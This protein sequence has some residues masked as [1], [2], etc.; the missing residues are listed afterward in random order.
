[1]G[2]EAQQ[3]RVPGPWEQLLY[4]TV[5]F[6]RSMLP[7]MTKARNQQ[8]GV[9]SDFM[10]LFGFW[11]PIKARSQVRIVALLSFCGS[12]NARPLPSFPLPLPHISQHAPVQVVGAA[13]LRFVV[14]GIEV[15]TSTTPQLS[16]IY[17][18][19]ARV[20]LRAGW[21]LD[22]HMV[23]AIQAILVSCRESY[24]RSP[25]TLNLKYKTTRAT[26]LRIP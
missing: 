18:D 10:S 23:R 12:G 4:Y 2:T 7:F 17:G 5:G 25:R 19:P 20:G 24:T 15:S 6:Q 22:R 9:V 26:Q 14:R 13:L 16:N 11:C 3:W 1:M 21:L 8:M